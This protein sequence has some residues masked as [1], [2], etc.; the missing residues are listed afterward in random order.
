MGEEGRRLGGEGAP[1]STLSTI[2]RREEASQAEVSVAHPTMKVWCI[3]VTTKEICTRLLLCKATVYKLTQLL[4][5]CICRVHFQKSFRPKT[6]RS[7][8]HPRIVCLF[9]CLFV[10]Q[11]EESS[12]LCYL[13]QAVHSM[14]QAVTL[15][16]Q[17][18]DWVHE[19]QCSLCVVSKKVLSVQCYF[20]TPLLQELAMRASLEIVNWCGGF[21]PPTTSQY[22]A[23][24]QV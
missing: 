2:M 9:E 11:V 13:A 8:V 17:N 12:S 22:L 1:H 7:I 20:V 4:L 24:Y 10:L 21:D 3:C 6:L 16:L 19:A 14:T 15:A 23:L 18:R 5:L